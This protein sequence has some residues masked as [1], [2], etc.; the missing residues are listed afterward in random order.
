MAQLEVRR[1]PLG[2]QHPKERV[3]NY[4]SGLMEDRYKELSGAEDYQPEAGEWD[5][6][7]AKWK[8]GWRPDNCNAEN[9]GMTYEQWEGQRPHRDNYMPN[10]PV[11]DRTH[12]MMYET[13]S[14]GTPI[15]P[16]F[17]TPEEL[18]R[19][20]ADWAPS[21]FAARGTYEQWLNEIVRSLALEMPD[22]ATTAT[23]AIPPESP[24]PAPVPAEP[25]ARVRFTV[26]LP[27]SLHKRLKLAAVD[28]DLPMTDLARR[29][30]E[31]WLNSQA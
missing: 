11:E 10:W 5:D 16:A 19:W 29:A 28:R 14:A 20:L 4:C 27:R 21:V 15:S 26:D 22:S 3:F 6:E 31:E 1:V 9:H 8:A 7:C 24:S 18:A 13:T 23:P 17:A 30:L 25:E 12:L 2:W